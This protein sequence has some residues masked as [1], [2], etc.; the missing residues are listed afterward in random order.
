[1][2]RKSRRK[3][4]PK[5]DMIIED[6]IFVTMRDGTQLA[7]RIYRPDAI[8][9][10]PALAA[11]SP[12][13]FVTDDLPHST[14]FLWREVGPVEWY[15]REHG[16]AYVRVDVRGTGKSDGT[17]NLLDYDEQQDIYELIEWISRQPWCSG[18]VGGF[19]QSYYAWSQW[20]MGIMNP[21]GLACIAPY[22]GAVDIYRGTAYHGGIYCDFM[23]TWYNLIRVNNLHRAANAP[24]GKALTED[25]GF[26][27]Q[28]HQTYDDWW[29]ERSAWEWLDQIKVPTYSIG[30]WGKMGLHLRGNILG[31]EDV[32]APKKL[33]VT[34]AR[35]VFEAHDLFDKIE[36][37]ERELLPFYAQHLK[38]RKNKF[39]EKAPVKIYVRGLEEYR[40]EKSWPIKGTRLQPFY[41]SKGPSG[42][43]TSQND[44]GLGRKKEGR[45]GG[46]TEYSYPDPAWKLGVVAMGPMGPDPVRRALP[47]TTPPLKEDLEVIGPV[48]LKLFAS[49]TTTDTDFFVRIQDQFPQSA[50]DRKKGLQPQAITM[51]KGWLR[52]SH[53]QLDEKRST[54]LRP[55]YTHAD[56]QPIAPGKIYQFDIEVMPFANLFRKG[57]R[58]RL[59]IINGDSPV[60]DA[61]FTHQYLYYKVGTDTIYHSAQHPSQLLLPVAPKRRAKGR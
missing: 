33:T 19:G 29:K 36:Y 55:I 46:T 58:I 6:D 54:K 30:H 48:V 41:L 22:D 37:H 56:P 25:I 45:G 40:E 44:G 43:V 1:M 47:F 23:A 52:A 5:Y 24:T 28:I 20:F 4:T 39:M 38:G 17:Y 11:I 12:Y 60:T 42:S 35:D 59:E 18:K 53:R 15:V 50:A 16:Y 51:S 32:K 57:H 49:S 10:F 8:G 2:A 9:G 34:G 26:E 3:S 14:Q 31:Y 61:I 27:M 13:Q 21:P 7:P